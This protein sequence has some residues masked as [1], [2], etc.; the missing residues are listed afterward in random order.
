MA[1]VET[2]PIIVGG[3]VGDQVF[4]YSSAGGGTLTAGTA[5][6]PVAILNFLSPTAIIQMGTA[7]GSNGAINVDASSYGTIAFAAVNGTVNMQVRGQSTSGSIGTQ[8]SHVLTLFTA[9]AGRWNISTTSAVSELAANQV[10]ARIVGGSSNGLAIRNSG[11]SRDN[12]LMSDNG[13]IFT[14]S[15]GTTSRD[16]IISATSG[17]GEMQSGGAYQVNT[18]G[19]ATL[20]TAAS[21]GGGV[22]LVYFDG[23]ILRS[24][25]EAPSATGFS[26]LALM[27]SGGGL[28]INGVAGLASF[29]GAVT[30]L[31]VVNGIVTAAS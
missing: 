2:G 25:V 26:T 30:N 31:T 8:S 24:A 16:R 21:A 3:G 18:S 7:A 4:S 22:A 12:L 29:S 6:Y 15:N 14:L 13:A 19:W 1:R 5:A 27:K 11:N 28:S 23:T 10:T 17:S 20:G 9:N